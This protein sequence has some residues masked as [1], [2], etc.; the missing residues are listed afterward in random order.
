MHIRAS[1][2]N[3]YEDAY[4]MA[5][6]CLKDDKFKFGRFIAI[7]KEYCEKTFFVSDNKWYAESYY[8]ITGGRLSLSF[9]TR[10]LLKVDLQSALNEGKHGLLAV[11]SKHIATGEVRNHE[12][13][14]RPEK[15]GL[16]NIK[17]SCDFTY[18]S[19]CDKFT[20]YREY[21]HSYRYDLG[22]YGFQHH[23]RDVDHF[24]QLNSSVKDVLKAFIDCMSTE[25]LYLSNNQVEVLL[26][27]EGVRLNGLVF[28]F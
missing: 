23:R 11:L 28:K 20:K 4:R 2:T 15:H 10:N 3:T 6:E 16:T 17:F 27:D 9:A 26:F 7:F 1:L 24:H 21:K 19:M 22:R 13:L 12:I 5:V 14:V 18:S 25:L 8:Y